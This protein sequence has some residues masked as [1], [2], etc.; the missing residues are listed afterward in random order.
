MQA[1][2]DLHGF[3]RA[4]AALALRDFLADC[5]AR[6]L[7]GVRVIHGK[8]RRSANEGPILKPAVAGWL[9]RRSEVMAFCSAR[10]V[11]GGSGALYVLLA[12]S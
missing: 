10:P 7:T 12:R 1:E 2:L 8:G 3:N 11:D 4:E 5:R 9:R 6:G